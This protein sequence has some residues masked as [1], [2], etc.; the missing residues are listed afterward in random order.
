MIQQGISH[1][2][3][4]IRNTH[5]YANNQ[6]QLHGQ[7][8]DSV[9]QPASVTGQSSSIQP[10]SESATTDSGFPP[11]IDIIPSTSISYS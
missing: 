7:V 8:K 9:F 5:I 4:K 6:L 11:S 3:I 10:D 1:K 2:S